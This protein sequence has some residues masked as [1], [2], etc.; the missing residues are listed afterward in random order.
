MYQDGVLNAECMALHN[1][2]F[3]Y[4]LYERLSE[5]FEI[6]RVIEEPRLIV[7]RRDVF[8]PEAAKLEHESRRNVKRLK[9][10]WAKRASYFFAYKPNNEAE[11]CERQQDFMIFNYSG[12]GDCSEFI[13]YVLYTSC[14]RTIGGW[15]SISIWQHTKPYPT[16]YVRRLFAWT[17]TYYFLVYSK[18]T[19][20]GFF[21]SS[22]RLMNKQ[23]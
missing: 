14:S 4:D 20:S 6:D 9:L 12:F 17:W 1:V 7:S 3:D 2:G 21:S 8:Y 13:L 10:N 15:C 19:G 22:S 23:I 18:C 11:Y 16:S 5:R